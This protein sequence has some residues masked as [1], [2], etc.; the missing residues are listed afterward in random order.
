MRTHTGH[1]V[2]TRLGRLRGASPTFSG[3]PICAQECCRCKRT[4]RGMRHPGVSAPRGCATVVRAAWSDR[5]AIG[6]FRD[7]ICQFTPQVRARVDL[8]CSEQIPDR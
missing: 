7:S 3:E 8:A 2:S 6:P 4:A 5:I 1:P